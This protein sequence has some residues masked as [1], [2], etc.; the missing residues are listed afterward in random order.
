MRGE[1]AQVLWEAGPPSCP[2]HVAHFLQRASWLLA[3]SSIG[4]PFCVKYKDTTVCGHAHTL[5][6]SY[7][8][9]NGLAYTHFASPSKQTAPRS[10]HPHRTFHILGWGGIGVQVYTGLW[11]VSPLSYWTN[12]KWTGLETSCF[13]F[14]PAYLRSWLWLTREQKCVSLSRVACVFSYR[15]L[16]MCLAYPHS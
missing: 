15:R 2:F 8:V 3:Y 13:M 16:I 6:S 12:F 4:I 1:R 10:C 9:S 11:V 7:Q 5:P 14:W